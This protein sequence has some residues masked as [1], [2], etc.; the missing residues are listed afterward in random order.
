MRPHPQVPLSALPFCSIPYTRT[1]ESE[2]RTPSLTETVSCA[3]VE[4]SRT[5]YSRMSFHRYHSAPQFPR[6]AS[7]PQPLQ[8][9]FCYSYSFVT[10]LDCF[11]HF[12]LYINILR[13]SKC[14]LMACVT[15]RSLR[16]EIQTVASSGKRTASR[17]HRMVLLLYV[18]LFY[19]SLKLLGWCWLIKSNE[20]RVYNSTT[21]HIY[22]T[23]CSPKCLFFR[24]L[25]P[26]YMKICIIF[27][28][29]IVAH[30]SH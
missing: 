10:P 17:I 25:L 26:G 12:S 22:C 3:R 6:S 1:A 13:P 27:F 20:F 11:L 21:C 2:L 4:Q 28:F 9:G 16:C 29:I 23:V 7:H 5:V 18:S 8:R 15:V 30:K 19:F 24:S 14:F